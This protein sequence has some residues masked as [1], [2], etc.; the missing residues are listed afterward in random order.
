MKPRITAITLCVDDLDRTV[1]FYSEGLGFPAEGIMGQ[2]FEFGAVA[3]FDMQPGFRLA[4]W[5][6]RSR[7][8]SDG[9]CP[10]ITRR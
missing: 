8:G 2:A 7:D 3:F 4:L 9:H 5:P 6:R 1:R 10:S